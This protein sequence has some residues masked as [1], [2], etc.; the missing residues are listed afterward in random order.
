MKKIFLLVVVH[1]VSASTLFGSA[2]FCIGKRCLE[3][4]ESEYGV[5]AKRRVLALVDVMNEVRDMDDLTKMEKVNEFFN[6][7]PYKYDKKTWGVSDYWATRM[8]F[9]GKGKGD[10]EDFVIAKYFTLKE[11]GI[12]SS[13][14]CMLYAKSTRYNTS[15]MVL[16]YYETP[17]STPLILDNHNFKILPADVRSD[18]V[19]IHQFTEDELYNAKEAYIGK[20]LPAAKAQKRC[21]DELVITQQKEVK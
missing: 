15:H 13:K 12:S 20:V 18:I 21:W 9:I 3:N 10:C 16:A 1:I 4:L 5:L 19:P 2:P 11:L 6:Q 8:E 7:T 14:L 17:E